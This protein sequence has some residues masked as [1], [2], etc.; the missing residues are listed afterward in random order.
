[1]IDTDTLSIMQ[2]TLK[3]IPVYAFLFHQSVH[4]NIVVIY[5]N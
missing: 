3:E 5:D 1:M 2:G 4:D